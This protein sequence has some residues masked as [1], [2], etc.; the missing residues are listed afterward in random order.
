[1]L[2]TILVN[3][4]EGILLHPAKVSSATDVIVLGMDK[5]WF[6]LLQFLK[7]ARPRVVSFVDIFTL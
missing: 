1:M 4:I 5:A 6:M 7:A 3:L 2:V